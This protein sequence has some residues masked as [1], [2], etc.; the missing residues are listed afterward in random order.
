MSLTLIAPGHYLL[1][2]ELRGETI[3]GAMLELGP[4]ALAIGVE[5]VDS[6][7]HGFLLASP[8]ARVIG[9]GAYGAAQNG[10]AF[11]AGASHCKVLGARLEG[12]NSFGAHIDEGANRNLVERCRG[13]NRL[14][15]IGVRVG[16]WANRL[17]S[18]IAE[19]S[20]DNGISVTGDRNIIEGNIARG[21]GHSGLGLYGSNN[22]VVGN[23]FEGNNLARNPA[24]ASIFVKPDFGGAGANN[25][26]TGNVCLDVVGV[27]L[28]AGA[29]GNLLGVNSGTV[30]VS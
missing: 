5:I 25:V 9:G 20:T 19:G 4:G 11:R 18:N 8:G 12:N 26:I 1:T 16:C 7:A 14:E 15:L 24:Y 29:P 17:I 2:G 28:R 21:N 22:V 27:N 30:V 23:L 6:P 13:V 3:T 10:I